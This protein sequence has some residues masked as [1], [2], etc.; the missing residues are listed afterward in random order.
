[1]MVLW[2][3]KF[4][5][6]SHRERFDPSRI[7]ATRPNSNIAIFTKLL[8]P[9]ILDYPIWKTTPN[10]RRDCLAIFLPTKSLATRFREILCLRCL[11]SSRLA[12]QSLRII[13]TPTNHEHR[14]THFSPNEALSVATRCSVIACVVFLYQ[15]VIFQSRIGVEDTSTVCDHLIWWIHRDWKWASFV[16]FLAHRLF[17]EMMHSAPSQGAPQIAPILH[18]KA[19]PTRRTLRSRWTLAPR[20]SVLAHTLFRVQCVFGAPLRDQEWVA[21]VTTLIVRIAINLLL[22]THSVGSAMRPERRV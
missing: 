2:R 7:A 15:V 13:L 11:M 1:M 3:Q 20:E 10:T 19:L 6:C 5:I 8:A 14:M 4:H 12:S 21:T 9:R 22:C 16:K 18:A 17:A